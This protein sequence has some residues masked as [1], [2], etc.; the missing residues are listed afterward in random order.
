MWKKLLLI[1]CFM[2]AAMSPVSAED[3]RVL[4]TNG[5]IVTAGENKLVVQ[6]TGNISNVE[7]TLL[8]KVYFVDNATMQK[9]DSS[10][11]KVGEYAYAFYGADMTKSIPPQAKAILLVLGQ[12][13]SSIEYMRVS[14]IED[15]GDFVKVYYDNKSMNISEKAMKNYKSIRPGDEVLGW[16][17]LT[18]G[19]FPT[20]FNASYAILLNRDIAEAVVVTDMSGTIL[21]N[22]KELVKTQPTK[23]YNINGLAYL[24]LRSV[25]DA[26][27]YKLTWNAFTKSIDLQKESTK[28][29]LQIGSKGYWKNTERIVL[30]NV[31][32]IVDGKTFVPLEFFNNVMDEKVNI[33]E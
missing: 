14:K 6:G 18:T 10:K 19:S 21:V 33:K 8:G 13:D 2:V 4:N 7:L 25:T 12:G 31:P 17:N 28:V 9:V 11:I 15:N 1:C 24:P 30:E 23:I 22:N 20:A 26:L 3:S 27:G 5:T 32:R 16:Y 29:T